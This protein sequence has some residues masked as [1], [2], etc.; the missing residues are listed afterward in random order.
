MSIYASYLILNI[1][2]LHLKVRNL[3]ARKGGFDVS[4]F[5][6]LSDAHPGAVIDLVDQFRMN[7][8]IMLL[9]N[10]LIYSDRLKCGSQ[11]VAHRSLVL[12]MKLK[13]DEKQSTAPWI[14]ELLKERYDTCFGPD[15]SHSRNCRRKSIFVDTDAVPAK[16]S[17]LGDLI[18][19]KGEA[20][21][22]QQFVE[23]LIQR[24]VTEEQIGVISPYRQQIKLLSL[25]LQSYKN[26]E[27]L[28]ADRSQGREKD[29]IIISL[30]RSNDECQVR[31]YI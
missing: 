22:V 4:L 19:N 16:D 12:P 18:Q 7:A 30:V 14:W 23:A 26:I 21:L 29:C 6:R 28:T 27:L 9:S 2:Q 15:L 3:D 1:A 10:K 17:K 25:R 24:G 13:A 5:K 11:E 31:I 20:L 8:D